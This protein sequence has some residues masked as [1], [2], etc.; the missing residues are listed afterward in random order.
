MIAVVLDWDEEREMFL[1]GL[2][3]LGVAVR[4]YVVHSGPTRKPWES[5]ARSLGDITPL[6]PTDVDRLIA[7]Q[8]GT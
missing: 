7:A 4:T 6:D 3:S 1:H 8:E 2:R 5:A